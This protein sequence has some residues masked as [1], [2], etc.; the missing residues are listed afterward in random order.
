MKPRPLRIA[1][2]LVTLGILPACSSLRTQQTS[3]PPRLVHGMP[4]YLPIGILTIK[5]T[6]SEPTPAPK[7]TPG[8]SEGNQTP[9]GDKPEDKE[10]PVPSDTS[11]ANSV[12]FTI[13]GWTI[14]ITAEVEA[15]PNESLYIVPERNYIFDDEYR[16]T[17]NPK[18]L[19]STGNTTVADR[20]AD[21][22]GAIAS[23]VSSDVG[24]GVHA[25][26]P[27]APK[28]HEPFLITF[29]P[30]SHDEYVNAQ[31][32]IGTRDFT[33]TARYPEPV[34]QEHAGAELIEAERHGLAFRL[35]V[36]FE[37]SLARQSE[38]AQGTKVLKYTKRFILPGTQTYV[39][40]YRRMPFVKKVTE[41]AFTDGMLTDY[42][43][44]LPSPILGVLSIP[45]AILAALIPL[46]SSA[47]TGGS[48]G[49]AAAGKA[50]NQ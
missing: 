44:N 23:L 36:P 39:F 19:L 48:G 20:S 32:L 31:E 24:R 38:R 42:H 25:G 3:S 21:I 6:Y 13:D 12:T 33:L 49:T 40:D 7:T 15:D 14:A 11:T 4:Y 18:H 16:V 1:L 27:P 22:A 41:I 8:A 5:G 29:H 37:V 46:P 10:S 28:E 9:A 43:E 26:A 17:V 30:T 35:G 34:G 45:K 47:M 50:P 2:Y